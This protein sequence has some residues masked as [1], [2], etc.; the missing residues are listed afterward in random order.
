ML[1]AGLESRLGQAQVSGESSSGELNRSI[2]PLVFQWQKIH[3]QRKFMCPMKM[4]VLPLLHNH[5]YI[6][7]K[8]NLVIL[9]WS[10]YIHIKHND[11]QSSNS[12][13]AKIA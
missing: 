5:L 6:H 7:I 4:K 12:Y 1:P 10:K 8:H 11:G 2:G 3:Y 13:T 9:K